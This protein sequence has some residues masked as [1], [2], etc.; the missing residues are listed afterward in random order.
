[1]IFRFNALAIL[2]A[3]IAAAMVSNASAEGEEDATAV[4][5]GG[6]FWCVESD[7]EK[8]E[9]VS[10]VVSGYS[11]GLLENPSYK[12][13]EGHLEAAE[14][15]YDPSVVTYRE[16]IDYLLRHIDPLDEGGQFCDR[17]HSYTSAIFAANAD[18]WA[19]AQAAVEEAERELGRKIVTPILDKSAF[20]RAEEYH[21]DYYKKNPLRYRYYRTACRRDARVRAIWGSTDH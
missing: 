10:E 4:F 8:L 7:F 6:C 13:H 5:A 11:G 17:G 18:E 14:I 20:W 9:G 19:E 1:M 2:A 15:H 12:N 16:L 3:G 21:Q